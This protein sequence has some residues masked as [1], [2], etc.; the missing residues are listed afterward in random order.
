MD[1]DFVV[2]LYSR[3]DPSSYE[4]LPPIAQQPDLSSLNSPL[5]L[6]LKLLSHTLKYAF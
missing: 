3:Y 2:T 6:E 5:I 1:F 4:M